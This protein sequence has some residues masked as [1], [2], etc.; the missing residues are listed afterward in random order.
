[1]KSPYHYDPMQLQST[2][3][4]KHRLDIFEQEIKD[5]ITSLRQ[6]FGRITTIRHHQEL[7]KEWDALEAKNESH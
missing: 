7:V 4:L 5:V 3:D 1:M 2:A 6:D